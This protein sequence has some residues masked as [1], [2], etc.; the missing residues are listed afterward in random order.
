ML[1]LPEQINELL[2]IIHTNQAII[3]GKQFGLEYLSEYEKA[4]LEA[5]G[6]DY[7]NLYT[8]ENDSI[9]GSFNLGMLAQ[10]LKDTK[11]LN[12]LT[13]KDL[14]SYIKQGSYIPIT[15]KEQ[16]VI[17]SIKNQSLSD[18]R[19]LNGRQYKKGRELI[20]KEFNK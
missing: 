16:A 1:L 3:I 14:K 9:F 10:A 15:K 11:A 13:Y 19:S 6:V 18:I 8:E 20:T 2:T 4:L 7:Q 17:Y 12:K 5:N